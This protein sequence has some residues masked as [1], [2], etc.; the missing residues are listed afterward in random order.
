MQ[1][2]DQ[3]QQQQREL[4]LSDG[5]PTVSA[6]SKLSSPLN[7]VVIGPSAGERLVR[8]E[9]YKIGGEEEKEEVEEEEE[10][11]AAATTAGGGDF[12]VIFSEEVS[13]SV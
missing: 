6:R 1:D 9:Y 10:T 11:T 7:P 4:H 2:R 12:D 5:R 3:A 8:M 13:L